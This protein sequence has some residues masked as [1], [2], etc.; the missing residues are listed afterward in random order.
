MSE[1]LTPAA[2]NRARK[3]FDVFNVLNSASFGILSGSLITLLA[4]KLGATASFVGLLNAFAYVSFFFMPLGK[5]LIG[6]RPILDV[7][8][9]GW[10]WRYLAMLPV[11]A[12]PLLAL[13]GGSQGWAFACLFAGVAGFN[14]FRGIGMIGS[15]PVT[16]SLAEGGDRGAFVSRVQIYANLAALGTNLAV[17]LVMGRSASSLVYA[18]LM[19]A[20]IAIGLAGTFWLRKVPEPTAY[21][22][23]P[24]GS[25]WKTT[26]EAWKEKS[27]RNFMLIYVLVCFTASMGKTFLPMYAKAIYHQGDDAVM[28][29]TLLASLGGVAAGM[30]SRLV[31]D[32]LGAKPLYGIYGFLAILG[33]VPAII[34]PS[35]PTFIE[36]FALLAA[37]F[38]AS[39]FGLTGQD[40]AGQ[41]YYFALVPRERTLD[42]A[43]AYFVA[44]GIGGTFGSIFGGF[45]LDGFGALGLGETTSWR[46]FYGLVGLLLLVAIFISRGMIRLGSASVRESLESLLSLRDLRTFDILTRLDQSGDP[47][48]ELEL[49]HELGVSG[50]T[51]SQRDLVGFLSSPRFEQR[52]EAL[53]SLE[54]LP[55]LAPETLVALRGE[56]ERRADTTGY[57]AARILGKRG[58]IEAIPLLRAALAANDPLLRGAAAIALARLRD[59]ESRTAIETLLR[60]SLPA[61]LRLQAVFALELIGSPESIPTLVSSLSR[62]D[63]PAFVSDEIVLAMASILGIMEDFWPLY[64]V[65]SEDEERGLSLLRLSADERLASRKDSHALIGAFDAALAALFSERIEGVPLAKLL[66]Q[67]V[68][69]PGAVIVFA[70]ALFDQRLV[71]GG[72][73]FLA[74]AL[75]VFGRADRAA[76]NPESPSAS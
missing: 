27:F 45:I 65:F 69:D 37:L 48:E 71:Y 33:F 38:L 43:V 30:L 62:D 67:S 2:R 46:M 23:A 47:G 58:D 1:S 72:F 32:R 40:G 7:Y 76:G 56:V 5:R 61:R 12:A 44:N 13:V 35:L 39:S 36:A 68:E 26:R 28:I 18:A 49:I 4:L 73:R 57:V 22:P 59:E 21:R 50:S 29:L 42:L 34:S 20:G 6:K 54:A 53:H 10:V 24:G 25:I 74:A 66:L 55:E 17:S 11:A 31:L 75:L 63:P 52:L 51:R 15:N 60:D 70:D 19:G 64:Q 9:F 3:A 14:I 41:T 16:A 8:F